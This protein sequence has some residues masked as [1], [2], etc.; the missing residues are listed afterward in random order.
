MEKE[1]LFNQ[2]IKMFSI[3]T[4]GAC[5]KNPGKGGWGFVVYDEN[6]NELDF[7]NG[8][9]PHTTNNRM[10]LKAF[11]EALLF[12]HDNHKGSFKILTDSIY[13][14]KGVTEWMN[15]WKINGWKTSQK[16]E[17][18]NQDL[19]CLIDQN[20]IPHLQLEWV[21]GHSESLG[22]NRADELAN[23]GIDLIHG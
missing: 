15:R 13:V 12:I 3:Y 11:Y 14:F 16:K 7:K 18:L 1:C 20:L 9:E 6:E 8:G 10:E 4:D 19:W 21:K 2:L 23:L 17:V 22:N 5:K